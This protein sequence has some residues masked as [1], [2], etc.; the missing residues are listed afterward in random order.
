ME[1]VDAAITALDAAVERYATV[2]EDIEV[3]DAYLGSEAWHEDR[4]AD[5]AGWLP[6]GMHRGVLG[7][8]GIWNLLERNR[9]VKEAMSEICMTSR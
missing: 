6:R 8:D 1:R 4:V 2:Q 5:E 7:E 3:L 9:E